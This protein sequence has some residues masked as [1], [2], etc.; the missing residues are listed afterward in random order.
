MG[1]LLNSFGLTDLPY[2]NEKK[3]II[4][5]KDTTVILYRCVTMV[6]LFVILLPLSLV[7]ELNALKY[8]SAAI[9]V[10]VFF[11]IGVSIFEAPFF[12][13][14]NHDKPADQYHTALYEKDVDWKW[15]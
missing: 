9:L 12:Y 3:M 1:H 5:E 4:D 8:V 10:I 14:Q 7:R 13:A 6:A 2:S 15:A 11:T